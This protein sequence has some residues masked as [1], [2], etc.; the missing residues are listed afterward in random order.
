MPQ[1]GPEPH[2]EPRAMRSAAPA[3]DR[4]MHT[5]PRTAIWNTLTA[6]ASIAILFLPFYGLTAQRDPSGS[7]EVPATTV[8]TPTPSQSADQT[9]GQGGSQNTAA[10]S[11]TT[12]QAGSQNAPAPS[13]TTGQGGS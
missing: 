11:E 1:H 4:T 2:Q 3:R 13:Q 5:S 9:T 6:L 10:P 12:G 7:A 8:A